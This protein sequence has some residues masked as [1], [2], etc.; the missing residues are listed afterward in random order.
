M[1]VA[2]VVN[3][4]DEDW[5]EAE[6]RYYA[7]LADE[8]DYRKWRWETFAAQERK[9][10]D[11]VGERRALHGFYGDYGLGEVVGLVSDDP[12]YRVTWPDKGPMG[13]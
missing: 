1:N 5:S 12:K 11:E 10:R 2:T 7:S 6:D 8:E 3:D 9:F 13:Q 4:A